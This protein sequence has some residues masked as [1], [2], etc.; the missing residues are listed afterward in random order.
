M[1]KTQ[2]IAKSRYLDYFREHRQS[3]KDS[4]ELIADCI[5]VERL[6]LPEPRTASGIILVET[7]NQVGSI[8][9]DRPHFYRVLLPGEGYFD[10]KSEDNKPVALN[11]EQGDIILVGSTSVKLFSTFPLLESY[12]PDTL[13][14]TR[15]SEIQWRFKGEDAFRRFLTEFNLSSKAK[16]EPGR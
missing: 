4:F 14:L 6:V 11:A 9:A 5:L 8:S 12:V 15:E 1:D 2:E 7:R 16:V 3:L 13:G 10:D